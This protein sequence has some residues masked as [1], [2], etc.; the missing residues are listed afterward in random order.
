MVSDA[1]VMD[2]EL[3]PNGRRA[4]HPES[5]PHTTATTISWLPQCLAPEL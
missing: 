5:P 2:V 4:A 1:D 3:E